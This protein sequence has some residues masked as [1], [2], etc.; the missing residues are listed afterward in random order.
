M[1]PGSFQT[2][3]LFSDDAC[4]DRVPSGSLPWNDKV[5]SLMG[6]DQKLD[7]FYQ[8]IGGK[9][10]PVMKKEL[11]GS[12]YCERDGKSDMACYKGVINSQSKMACHEKWQRT[13]AE[14][15]TEGGVSYVDCPSI[16]E[17]MGEVVHFSDDKCMTPMHVDNLEEL[18]EGTVIYSK[19][20]STCLPGIKIREKGMVC[21]QK[22]GGVTEET[23]MRNFP[24][25]NPNGGDFLSCMMGNMKRGANQDNPI[26]CSGP[27]TTMF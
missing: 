6:K 16:K 27:G 14:K 7:T 24:F 4:K 11:G 18:K 19:H 26:N 9:C 23:C 25:K 5:Y 3:N 17:K 12:V 8:E 21:L 20:E 15:K 10:T 2:D 1:P 13:K 22:G